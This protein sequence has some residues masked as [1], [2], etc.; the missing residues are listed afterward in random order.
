MKGMFIMSNELTFEE[1]REKLLTRRENAVKVYQSDPIL[2]QRIPDTVGELF[3]DQFG[4]YMPS[5]RLTV[6][7]VVDVT[8]K[9]ILKFVQ[10]QPVDQFSIEIAGVL[11]EYVT[12][13]SDSDKSTNIVPQMYHKKLGIFK[14]NEHNTTIGTDIMQEQL[15]KYNDW[16][17]GRVPYLE[18]VCTV[19]LHKLSEIMKVVRAYAVANG[20]K[21]PLISTE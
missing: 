18:A 13:I 19:N 1:K 21:P 8:W 9:H 2:S 11:L 10:Q 14:K 16:R 17:H 6:P 3:H 20:L 7:I 4:I 5:P 12:D 15:Q